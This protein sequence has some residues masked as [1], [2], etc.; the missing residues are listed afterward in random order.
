MSRSKS[1]AAKP[2]TAAPAGCG[3]ALPWQKPCPYQHS[4]NYG[5]Y[6]R[7]IQWL[8]VVVVVSS[9]S[10]RHLHIRRL[11]KIPPALPALPFPN[12]INRIGTAAWPGAPFSGCRNL[13]AL[14]TQPSHPKR[15]TY[16]APRPRPSCNQPPTTPAVAMNIGRAAGVTPEPAHHTIVRCRGCRVSR[17]V[18]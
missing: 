14:Y 8:Q 10:C 15:G 1:V 2:L 13:R 18:R 6:G 4:G 3:S 11:L 9:A 5:N 16:P 7:V 17:R 12:I